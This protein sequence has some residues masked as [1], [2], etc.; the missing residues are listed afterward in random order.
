MRLTNDM[1]GSMLRTAMKN[2]PNVD[3]MAMLEPIVQSVVRVHMPNAVRAAY[4]DTAS[5]GYLKTVQVVF[6]DGNKRLWQKYRVIGV[7][8]DRDLEIRVDDAS[9]GAMTKGGLKYDLSNAVRK[10][11]LIQK[12]QD[13]VALIESV[14]SRL[15]STLASVTTTNRLREVLEPELHYIIPKE[16]DPTANMPATAAPVADDLRKLG[17]TFGETK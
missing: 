8:L 7:A 17:A 10:S 13:Q 14:Q 3:Y 16:N 2:I 6:V 11:G 9:F 12:H 5:R 15:K 1:R 4:D